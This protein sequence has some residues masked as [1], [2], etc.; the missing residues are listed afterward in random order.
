MG[1]HSCKWQTFSQPI[2]LRETPPSRP[3]ASSSRVFW[4]LWGVTGSVWASWTRGFAVRV[5]MLCP[6]LVS[7]KG[8]LPFPSVLLSWALLLGLEGEWKILPCCRGSVTAKLLH[9]SYIAACAGAKISLLS[10]AVWTRRG[11]PK[12]PPGWSSW[13]STGLPFLHMMCAQMY[14]F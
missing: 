4:G 14:F 5:S 6:M 7:P 8:S 1:S 10:C 13:C 3:R 11:Q 9:S 2:A 12:R